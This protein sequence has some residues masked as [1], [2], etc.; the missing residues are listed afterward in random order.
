MK[1][2]VKLSP[3]KLPKIIYDKKLD[4]FEN[5]ILFPDAVKRAKET[6]AKIGLPKELE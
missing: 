6:L 4:K 2:K 1:A 5:V 3:D